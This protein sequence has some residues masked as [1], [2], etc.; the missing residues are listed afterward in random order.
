METVFQSF[1][2]DCIKSN[3]LE[4][5]IDKKMLHMVDVIA[6]SDLK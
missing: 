1:H 6:L 4:T 5:S 2:I 3:N